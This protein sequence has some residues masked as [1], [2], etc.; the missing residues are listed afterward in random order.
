[1]GRDGGSPLILVLGR[2]YCTA[3]VLTGISGTAAQNYVEALRPL[4]N[5]AGSPSSSRSLWNVLS[6]AQRRSRKPFAGRTGRASGK[7]LGMTT[8]RAVR[9][10]GGMPLERRQ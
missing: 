4:R 2:T 1:M 3:G 6:T 5:T 7:A 8:H 9:S 10:R